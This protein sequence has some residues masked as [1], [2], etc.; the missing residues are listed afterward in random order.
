MPAR[1]I[2]FAV[3]G[4]IFMERMMTLRR[5]F[6]VVLVLAVC[7]TALAACAQQPAQPTVS[8]SPSLSATP[9]PS[10]EATTPGAQGGTQGG[11]PGEA[12]GE[13]LADATSDQGKNDRLYDPS[14]YVIEATGQWRQEIAEGYWVDY[15]CEFYLDKIDANDNRSSAGAYSGFFWMGM[16]LDAGDYLQDF[17][18]D[19][20][21]DMSFNAGGEGICDNLV[22]SLN[23]R[24]DWERDSYALPMLDGAT[25][26]P[27]IDVPVDKGSFIV[28]ATQ[29]Y[30]NA[31]ATGKQGETLEHADDKTEDVEISYIIHMQPDKYEKGTE[32]NVSI[33]L[34]DGKGLSTMI[35]GKMHRLPGYPDD[36][37]QYTQ[38]APYQKALDKHLQ[39]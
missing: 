1:P 7:C 32:R 23:T 29:A 3:A 22:F 10:A 33:Y 12:P 24:E 14:I 37:T 26:S 8:P 6:C 30:L 34:S 4:G 19:V 28:V 21:V 11:V 20:P 2:L 17:L 13:Q 31:K 9:S 25:L 36:V 35:F 39:Q 18:K 27:K 5:I 15:E 38:D 16:K